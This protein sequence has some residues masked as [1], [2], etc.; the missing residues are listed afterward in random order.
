MFLGELFI[1]LDKYLSG[2]LIHHITPD[3]STHQ[4]LIRKWNFGNLRLFELLDKLDSQLSSFL[5]QNFST[6]RVSDI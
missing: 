2:F 1:A 3:H 6:F 5:G 4:V